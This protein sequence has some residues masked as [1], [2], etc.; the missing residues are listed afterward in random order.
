MSE[1]GDR[2]TALEYLP[3]S[4]TSTA[5]PAELPL[6]ASALS[7]KRRRGVT[8]RSLLV[9]TLAVV[10]VCA[11][12]PLNDLT[13][14]DTSLAAGYVPLAG[15]LV[16]FILIVGIN[17]PLHRWAPTRA[18]TSQE[19]AVVL[20]MT[21]V[22]CGIPNWGLMRFFIP[23][24]VAPFHMGASDEVFW[25]TFLG[26]KLPKW[27]FPVQSIPDGRTDP[28]AVWF[29]TR[30]PRGQHIPFGAWIV[31]LLAWGIFIAAMFA[32]LAALARLILEQWMLNERLPFPLVQ[33]Q[34][35]LIEDPLPGKCLN[36]M[37][38]SP[39]L[40]IGM[41]GVFGVLML[42]CLNAY[43]PR[44][45]PA[46]PLHYDLTNILSEE[47]FYYLR[48]KLKKSAVSFTVV[49]V[50]YFIR[51]RAAFSLWVTFILCNLVDVQYGMRHG[52]MPSQ[53]WADQHLG[54]CVAFVLG[55]L[56]IGRHHWISVLKGAF[57]IRTGDKAYRGTIWTLII[58][59]LVMLGWLRFV[60]VQWWMAGLI[61]LFILAAHVIVS[62]VV[63]ETG[64]PFYR[65]GISV[66]QIYS[67]LQPSLFS[68]R[69]IYFAN[70]FS[71]LGPVTTRDSIMT[72]SQQGLG[73][74]D[75]AGL[76]P[77]KHPGL[78][79]AIGWAMLIGCLVAAPVTLYCQ[80]SYP[81]PASGEVSPA[82]NYFGAT[83]VQKR[84]VGNP[85][86]EFARGHFAAKPDNPAVQMTLGFVI[87]ALLQFASLQWG[88]WPLLPVGYVASHGAFVEN[89][90]F[91]IFIGWLAQR[92]IV[93]LGGAS[94]FQRMRPFFI[95]IIFGE[96][97][98]AGVWLIINAALVMNGAQSQPVKFLL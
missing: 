71:V 18:L 79:R 65:T 94:L 30:V 84:D 81:T 56:W 72:L 21:L 61:V 24:P 51:S 42:S 3:I 45:F 16:A 9:G 39:L 88:A 75:T 37:F 14:S 83:Y 10:A 15:V 19:L 69:D 53:A 90:W 86:D 91:S 5:A 27:L 32:A 17:A 22:A 47:P 82:R 78:G 67:N 49:G 63:A 35:A 95:G 8:F 36:E 20:M 85:V 50:T 54:A 73:V 28:A 34:A 7:S 23:T 96:C 70:V 98:A 60:G 6:V 87:T 11:I 41:G 80:Y 93:S 12:T 57:G 26:M 31:P 74:C 68:A 4:M 43:Y 33:V 97:L 1:L 55:I 38:R 58:A 89:A 76:S 25:R 64:L 29:F 13:L 48:A 66:S 77:R 40:W 62:R 2:G 44:F 46:I 59:T 52:E 92:I